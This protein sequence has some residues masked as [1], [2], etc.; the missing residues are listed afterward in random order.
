MVTLTR[1]HHGPFES[2]GVASDARGFIPVS[3]G[4]SRLRALR[5]GGGHPIAS[6]VCFE[7]R[8][9]RGAWPSL[10]PPPFR[11]RALFRET[12]SRPRLAPQGN[13]RTPPGSAAGQRHAAPSDRPRLRGPP[14]ARAN[15]T[16]RLSASARWLHPGCSALGFG[17]QRPP[18]TRASRSKWTYAVGML[19][20]AAGLTIGV[21]I[22]LAGQLVRL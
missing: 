11:S 18:P 22:A 15:S 6:V 21:L 13:R 19:T 5:R 12:D 2:G 17:P 20:I 10:R 3:L 7:R 4:R 8:R 16:P 14:S 1:V 9:R